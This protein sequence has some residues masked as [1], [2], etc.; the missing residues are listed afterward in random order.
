MRTYNKNG[1]TD[2][3]PPT[4][5]WTSADQIP[6]ETQLIGGFDASLDNISFNGKVRIGKPVVIAS[7][8]IEADS[9][10]YFIQ[11]PYLN[12]RSRNIS[13]KPKNKKIKE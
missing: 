8:V 12:T 4:T 11:P 1:A 7:I 2:T 6:T 5:S 9:N 10:K 13:L 3:I